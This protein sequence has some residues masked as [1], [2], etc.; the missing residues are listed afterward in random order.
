[1][2]EIIPDILDFN[3]LKEIRELLSTAAYQDG[4][5]TAGYRAKRVKENQQVKGDAAGRQRIDDLV[6]DGL[7]NHK[8]FQRLAFPKLIQKP[9]L[10]RYSKGMKYGLHV[11]DAL[12]GKGTKSRTDISVTVFLNSPTEYEGGVLEMHSPFGLEEIKL[13]AGACVLYPSNTLHQVTEVTEGERQVAVTWVQSYVPDAAHREML[14]D[15]NRVRVHLHKS[16]PDSEITD[17]A[18]KTYTNL[19]RIWSDV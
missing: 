4:K 12:M 16:D 14:V 10:S 13:P 8:D 3:S 7:R 19:L 15:L 2:L 17:T 6:R 5:T 1:M 18:F 11:D 9:L